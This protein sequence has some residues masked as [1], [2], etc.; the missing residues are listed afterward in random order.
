MRVSVL[1]F[2]TYITF[3][4]LITIR[5]CHQTLDLIGA[6]KYISTIR[7]FEQYLVGDRQ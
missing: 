4:C 6:D 1:I 2:I 7:Q 5:T 3:A